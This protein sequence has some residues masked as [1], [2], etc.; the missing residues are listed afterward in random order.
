MKNNI[1]IIVS[2]MLAFILTTSFTT[3][4]LALSKYGSRGD[5]V[6]EI[7]K[8]L[9]NW[10]YYN[11]SIDGIYGTKTKQAVIK[12]QK[13][14]GLTADGIAGKKWVFTDSKTVVHQAI[15]I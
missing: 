3:Q 6:R 15:Q 2:V 7:Q 4:S 9:K 13:R 1:K 12:F 11:G 5:E 8:R 10:D 14:N